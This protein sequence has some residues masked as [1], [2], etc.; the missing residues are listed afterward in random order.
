MRRS[1]VA[2]SRRPPSP[3]WLRPPQPRPTPSNRATAATAPDRRQPRVAGHAAAPGHGDVT[4]VT[5]DRVLVTATAEPTVTVLP[6]EDG[7]PAARADPPGRRRRLRLPGGRGRGAR[8]RQG[9]RGALQRHRPGPPGLRRRAHA[10]D[11]ADRAR[12]PAPSPAPHRRPA[13][14]RTRRR[15]RVDRR[16]SRSSADKTKAADFWADLTNPRSRAA[17]VAQE[18]LARRQGRGHPRPLDRAG[19]RPRRLGGRIRRHGHHGRRPRHRRRRRAPRPPGP[20][21]R[22]RGLH[23]LGRRLDG[24]QRPRHPRRLHRRR[25]RR[26]QRRHEEGR[27]PAP[28]CSSA[29]SS[30]T[31]APARRPGSS[32]AWSG[33]SPRAPTS[34]R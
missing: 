27:R 10:D 30:T 12:T 11:P 19:R 3:S 20:H 18:A 9:R 8:R 5:G 13:R 7:T 22:G 16:V 21:H 24:R 31:A 28:T 14:R 2:P 17:G 1:G 29:R 33:P 6:R 23:R 4:L 32:P 34:S 25:H 15:P 26:G